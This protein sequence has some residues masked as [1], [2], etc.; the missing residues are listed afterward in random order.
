MVTEKEWNKELAKIDDF[1]SEFEF[2]VIPSNDETEFM[3]DVFSKIRDILQEE[4]D[5]DS[6]QEYIKDQEVD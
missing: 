1:I 5:W 3:M 6:L 4:A 2:S